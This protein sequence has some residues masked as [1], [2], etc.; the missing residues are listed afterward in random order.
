MFLCFASSITALYEGLLLELISFSSL[1]G[2]LDVEDEQDL[3]AVLIQR[4]SKSAPYTNSGNIVNL[5][6]EL[7][8]F[9]KPGTC[10]CVSK[11]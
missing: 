9:S 4:L 6:S 8:S 5:D 7:A 2:N 10:I 11:V 1:L 3:R